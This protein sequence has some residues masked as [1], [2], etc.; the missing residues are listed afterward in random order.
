[1]KRVIATGR[2]VDEAVTSALVQL[3]VTRSNANVRVIREPV[4]GL[5]GFIGG[6][7]AEVE[8]SVTM[9][10]EEVARD[11]LSGV[12]R[13]MKLENARVKE[14]GQ[15]VDGDPAHV[16]EVVCSDDE[17]PIVIGRHGATLDSLQYLVNVVGNQDEKGKYTKFIVDAG[18]YRARH[19]ENIERIAER[20]RQRAIKLK[21]PVTLEA[22][23]AADRKVVHT[24]LQDRGGVT[25]SSEGT[26]P[27]RRVVITPLVESGAVPG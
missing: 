7:E 6:K 4:K 15:V 17:L 26:D 27:N 5:F 1:M 20:A 19:K 2:T 3:G 10:A 8:V 25:T 14:K 18:G 11:F 13:R 24:Y 9:S 21:K 23:T 22:M 12:V 16:L